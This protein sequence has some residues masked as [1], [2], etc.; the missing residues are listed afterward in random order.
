MTRSDH[1]Y[2]TLRSQ[3]LSGE[4]APG[5]HVPEE[6]LTQALGV[7]RTPVRAALQRLA[8]EG[9]VEVRARR[10]AFVAEFT[11]ADVD[12]DEPSF[13]QRD[14]GSWL[15]AGFMPADEGRALY[16][17]AVQYLADGVGVDAGHRGAVHIA[18]NGQHDGQA[19]QHGRQ[20][21]GQG[22]LVDTLAAVIA[23]QAR[24]RQLCRRNQALRSTHERAPSPFLSCESNNFDKDSTTKV[25]KKRTR[26][27]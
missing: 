26:P 10:G 17:T 3:I 15:I 23:S 16:C 2:E 20:R 13:V 1:V 9:L 11:R 19:E 14:D 18:D 6:S 4:R 21:Q 8:D 7:S 5:S 12:E 25:M 22:D 27:R 24:L